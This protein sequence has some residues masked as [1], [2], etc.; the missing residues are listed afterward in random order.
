LVDL[1]TSDRQ[2]EVEEA[3]AEEVVLPV[4]HT[5]AKELM[6]FFLTLSLRAT[7]VKELLRDPY[8]FAL[9]RLQLGDELKL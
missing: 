5:L 3:A 9:I 8:H 2:E 1:Q 7:G 4:V 6:T